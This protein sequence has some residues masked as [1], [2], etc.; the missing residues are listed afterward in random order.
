VL[1]HVPAANTE[2]DAHQALMAQPF[3]LG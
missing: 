2:S 3:N 1:E